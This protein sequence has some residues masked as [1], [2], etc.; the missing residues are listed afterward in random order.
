MLDQ[1]P[2]ISSSKIK[3]LRQFILLWSFEV[4]T[5]RVQT[6]I[7]QQHIFVVNKINQSYFINYLQKTL[8]QR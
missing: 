6:K 3:V 1:V 5:H 2:S 4:K 7:Q 8:D